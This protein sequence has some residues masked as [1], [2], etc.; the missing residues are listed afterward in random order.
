MNNPTTENVKRWR[1]VVDAAA[2]Q[3]EAMGVDVV[4][5]STVSALENYRIGTLEEALGC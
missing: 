1:R 3:I 4:N 2:E 5:C